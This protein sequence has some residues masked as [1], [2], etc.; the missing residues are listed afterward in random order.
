MVKANIEMPN[1]EMIKFEV[2]E[3]TTLE[4]ILKK[5]N[6]MDCEVFGERYN[7]YI[8]TPLLNKKLTF[9]DYNK[10]FPYDK[11]YHPGIVILD[12]KNMTLKDR[13]KYDFYK[14]VGF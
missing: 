7:D 13:I 3:K 11:Y 14:S 9:V 6:V 5:L 12:T 8:G 1:G 4:E 10:W 2:T